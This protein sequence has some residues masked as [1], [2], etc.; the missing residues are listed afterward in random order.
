MK[1]G[2]LDLET[3]H[4]PLER[5]VE[6]SVFRNFITTLIIANALILGVLTYERELPTGLVASLSWID[7]AVTF[8]FAFEIALKLF[9]YRLNFFRSGWNWFD[10]LVVG[11]S[12]VPGGAAFSV[13]R[14]LRVLRV[15]RLLHI[16]PMM[17]RITEA[18]LNALPGMGAILAVLALLTYVGAVMATNMYGNTDNPEVLELFGDLPSSAYSL[19]QVMTM[20][21][22][23]FEVVQ[24]VVDDGHPYAPLFFLIFIFVASFAVLNLFIALIVDALAEE[25]R[26]ATDEHLEEI[27][28]EIEEEFDSADKERDQII[29]ILVEL[30]KDIAALK[31]EKSD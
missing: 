3:S 12:L 7:Q 27:E 25:Q 17:R 19:F 5:A 28:E 20:D 4:S 29:E 11:I 9:V 14:A 8:V 24:K 2:T 13:L 1:Q 30:K 23:R 6:G 18:L 16:V 26:A 10:F 22:W 21:G 15:L 31:A